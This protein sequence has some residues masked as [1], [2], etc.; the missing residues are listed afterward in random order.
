MKEK[1]LAI[2][3][4]LG[5]AYDEKQNDLLTELNSLGL[6]N[7]DKIEIPN[8]VDE[9]TKK[10]MQ[11]LVEQNKAL[12]GNVDILRQT[13]GE[14]KAQRDAAILAEQTRQ[15]A[16]KKSK[17]ESAVKKLLDEKKITE[18]DKPVWE[19]LLDNDFESSTKVAEQLK[20]IGTTATAADKNF[21]QTADDKN[22]NSLKVDRVA[23]KA[24]ITEKMQSY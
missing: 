18:A 21:Q 8:G 9:A 24:A 11:A 4:K 7:M 22:N 6:E 20:P 15:K 12:A 19:K 23:L 17:V 14:E 10:I 2:L 13:L 16:E 1:I 3:K 5:I